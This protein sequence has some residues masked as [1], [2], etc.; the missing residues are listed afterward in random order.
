[1]IEAEWWEYD[2]LDEL[3]D[4]VAGDVGFII[5]SAVDARDASLIAV[6][7]GKTGPAI[8]P[9]SPRRS[10]RGSGSR[11]FRPTTGW[12]RW[13]TSAAMSARS[14]GRSCRPARGSIPIAAE[15]AD[16]RLAGNS[17]DARLQDL[18]WPPDLVWLG[19]GED[20]HTASIF[21][22]PDMQGRSMR[23]RRAARSA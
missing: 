3:A 9:S 11:S 1:M 13:T 15:I 23:P 20:G 16:Y 7:G 14:P 6:P 21:A 19:M 12:C 22:G 5:E 18:P 2:S 8:F 17:A 10:C 4:A